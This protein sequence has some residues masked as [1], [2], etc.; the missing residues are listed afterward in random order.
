MMHKIVKEFTELCLKFSEVS[1]EQKC[2]GIT[3]RQELLMLVLG[4]NGIILNVE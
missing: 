4:N 3:L 1:L 2:S